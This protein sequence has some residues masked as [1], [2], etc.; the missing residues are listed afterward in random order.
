MTSPPNEA[1]SCVDCF[2]GEVLTKPFTQEIR[3]EGR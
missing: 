1:I 2:W 3:L